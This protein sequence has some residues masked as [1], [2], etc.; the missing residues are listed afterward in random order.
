MRACDFCKGKGQVS[1]EAA[2]RWREG[3]AM[4]DAGVKQ[5]FTQ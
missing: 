2:E 1:S 3:R 5:G 4:R